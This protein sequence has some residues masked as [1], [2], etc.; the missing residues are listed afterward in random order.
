MRLDDSNS[1]I[2]SLILDKY[3]TIHFQDLVVNLIFSNV[4]NA[5]ID[6]TARLL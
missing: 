6:F 3:I 1:T 2:E 5:N 4:K